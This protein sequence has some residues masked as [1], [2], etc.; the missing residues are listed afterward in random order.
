MKYTRFFSLAAL[1]LIGNLLVAQST[2]LELDIF[3]GRRK[4]VS[5]I[6]L[7]TERNKH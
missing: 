2:L 5:L 7:N 1:L 6:A 3:K 4:I